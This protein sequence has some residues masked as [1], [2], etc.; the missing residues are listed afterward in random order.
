[1]TRADAP[2]DPGGGLELL[3]VDEMAA[4]DR[5]A[6]AAGVAVETLMENAGRA[7]VAAMLARFAPQPVAVLCGPGNNGGDGFVIARLLAARGWTVTVA[8]ARPLAAYDGAA[9][10]HA[11]RWQGPVL[12][13]ELRALDGAALV[14]DALFGAGLNRPVAGAAAALLRAVERR[15]LPMVAVDMPSGIHGDSGQVHGLAVKAQLTVSFFRAKPGHYLMPGR[16][17]CG[18]LVI[19][20]IGIPARVLETIRPRIRLNHPA[21][22]RAKLPRPR[23]A[24]HKYDRGHLLIV[25]GAMT[26]AARLAARGGRR[27]GAGLVTV[28]CATA[29][30]AIYAAD[31]PGM[32]VRALGGPGGRASKTVN[33]AALAA[34]LEDRRFNAL[35][36]GPGAGPGAATRRLVETALSFGR[37]TVIDADGLTAFAG[38]S[39]KLAASLAG[40]TVL[41]PHDGE[42]ARLCPTLTGTRLE[43]ARDAAR[44]IGAIVLLKGPDTVIAHPDGAVVINAHA[45]PT[46]ATAGAGDVLAGFIGGLLAQRLA[47]LPAAAAAAW[48]HGEAARHFGIGLIAE[49]LP[50]T[51][52]NVLRSLA[53]TK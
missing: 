27:I 50:E 25:G 39:D 13:L 17:L 11:V 42:F 3:T 23:A 37:A 22:W 43:R 51:L 41:T 38:A 35:V 14:V 4:A 9:G 26:G 33:E 47:P 52:P 53:E 29:D 19:A 36:I 46:L 34:L 40:P 31:Q 1:M 32:I 45:P 6:I 10:A 30:R 21:L 49:D 48:L 5:A 28:A 44:A 15:G 8:A 18:A 7:V 2:D 24:G 16:E 20:D 12:G